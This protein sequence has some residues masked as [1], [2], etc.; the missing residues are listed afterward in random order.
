MKDTITGM[1][2]PAYEANQAVAATLVSMF[3]LA[4][5]LA[6]PHL[7]VASLIAAC[8][9]GL[10]GATKAPALWT[11]MQ[12][13]HRFIG[14]DRPYVRTDG[15]LLAF[16]HDKS[17]PDELMLG[18]GYAWEPQHLRNARDILDMNIA[19]YRAKAICHHETWLI[20]TT[21]PWNF[22]LHPLATFRQIRATKDLIA[23]KR[24]YTWLHTLGESHP[25]YLR[26]SDMTPHTLITGSSGA[27]KTSL[28]CWLIAQE[29]A[30]GHIVLIIDPKG[31]NTLFKCVEHFCK[32]CRRELHQFRVAHPEQSDALNLLSNFKEVSELASR[33]A[34]VLPSS[35][36]S[37]VFN[38]MGRNALA[39]VAVGMAILGENPTIETL[40]KNYI[41][42]LQF[43][44][45]VLVT[46]LQAHGTSVESH[47]VSG[48]L[49]QDRINALAEL[50]LSSPACSPEVVGLVSFLKTSDEMLDKT[51]TSI[52]NVL[53]E[54]SKGKV[55]QLLSPSM[56]TQQTIVDAR[57]LIERQCV[58]YLGS[59]ALTYPSLGRLLCALF[60]ADLSG[61]AGDVYNYLEEDDNS[62]NKA[63][64]SISLIVDEASEVACGPLQD[65]LSKG[66]G[67]GFS[68]IA[69]TQ[70]V[71]DFVTRLGSEAETARVVAN[72]MNHIAMRNSDA[73]THKLVTACV[74]SV[75]LP[76][77]SWSRSEASDADELVA[78]AAQTQERVT[79]QS[80]QPIVSAELISALPPGEAF[81]IVS[82]NFVEK[83]VSPL[84]KV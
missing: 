31:D 14:A 53:S 83:L 27:G 68:I 34:Q 20:L 8:A 7:Q 39:A 79:K 75:S 82:G 2:R 29:I 1:I 66:R 57:M 25:R 64:P 21:R 16:V 77:R 4:V 24:G 33:I 69:A 32:K 54:L 67:A 11:R 73:S 74:P 40:F 28:L 62:Q 42:R 36:D 51:T 49:P 9:A 13:V 84:L 70:T 19:E 44:E 6:F 59:D 65:L 71:N 72:M 52:R 63:L 26:H 55:G 43:G 15:D 35:G 50:C 30:R 18:Y 45:R 48:K 60:L 38:E 41:N 76:Q 12:F 56:N 61:F 47:P 5:A 10:Y 23:Y 37:G 3:Y 17:H 46:W 58:F 78:R 81:A 80:E 22:L